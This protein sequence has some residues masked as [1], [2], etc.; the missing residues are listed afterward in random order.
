MTFSSSFRSPIS[1][2]RS[3]TFSLLRSSTSLSLSST[4]LTASSFW[5]RTSLTLLSISS[6]SS[7]T[8]LSLLSH[9]SSKSLTFL[10]APSSS[11]SKSLDLSSHSSALLYNGS[12][13]ASFCAISSSFWATKASRSWTRC[14]LAESLP[15]RSLTCYRV[16]A[17]A[18][19]N[20]SFSC[21][22]AICAAWNCCWS[23]CNWVVRSATF[24][25]SYSSAVLAVLSYKS[26]SK[27]YFVCF[28][29]KA[30]SAA[31]SLA[32]PH[33]PPIVVEII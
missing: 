23:I 32:P 16:Y 28:A 8:L 33:K 3:S 18:V 30:S 31:G 15:S 2:S 22:H 11:R 12:T 17:R 9:S 4:Y 25:C 5:S 26:M 6:S 14:S 21:P 1:F 7:L 13:I 27:S 29:F 19:S 24:F 20:A 10:S